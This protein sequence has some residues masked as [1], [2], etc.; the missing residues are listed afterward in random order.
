VIKVNLLTGERQVKKAAVPLLAGQKITVACSLILLVAALVVGWRYWLLQQESV[1]LDASIAEA[2]TETT[3]LHSI[4]AQVQQFEQRRTQLQQRVALI[5]Q[6][7][8]DQTGPVHMLDQIS[9]ALPPMVWLTRLQQGP[10]ANDVSIE[11]RGTTLTGLSDFVVNLEASG[12]FRRSVEIVSSQIME[13]QNGGAEIIQFTIKAQFQ[14]PGA[15]AVMAALSPS[16]VSP[17]SAAVP[18]P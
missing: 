18:A 13:L 17:L 14:Q 15:P 6:L 11:G 7:R 5:E 10:T 1:A 9:R 16:A 4:I 12:Y 3:R 8:R 2:Q